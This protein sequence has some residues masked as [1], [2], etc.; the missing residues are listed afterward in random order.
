VKWSRRLYDQYIVKRQHVIKASLWP[1][2]QPS[3]SSVTSNRVP[4]Y[5][6][7][8]TYKFIMS[9]RQQRV[10]VQPIVSFIYYCRHLADVVVER[11]IPTLTTGGSSSVSPNNFI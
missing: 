7:V 9:G 6:P 3:D 11:D 8:F 10:M 2:C 1:L 4:S 5:I